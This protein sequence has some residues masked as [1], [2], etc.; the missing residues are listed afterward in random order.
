MSD[1]CVHVCCTYVHA[2]TYLCMYVRAYGCKY[3]CTVYV[4]RYV[5]MYEIQDNQ[6]KQ[7]NKS[8]TLQRQAQ[9]NVLFVYVFMYVRKLTKSRQT[10]TLSIGCEGVQEVFF[11][12]TMYVCKQ[13]W[14]KLTQ[15]ASC[16]FQ[17]QSMHSCKQFSCPV[18]EC[19][20]CTSPL[21]LGYQTCHFLV[22]V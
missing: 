10:D 9:N 6:R 16:L 11:I 2:R 1:V 7:K 17:A 21:F 20:S 18:M 5:C 19:E 15:A 4:C 3:I 13:I 8:K 22:P 12:W 14:N